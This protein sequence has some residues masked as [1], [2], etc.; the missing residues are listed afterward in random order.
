M[1]FVLFSGKWKIVATGVVCL[2]TGDLLWLFHSTRFAWWWARESQIFTLKE[3]GEKER[4]RTRRVYAG[5]RDLEKISAENIWGGER[6]EITW[7]FL[8]RWF[9]WLCGELEEDL[10]AMVG[11]LVRN[12]LKGSVDK[13]KVMVLNGEKGLKCA[14]H[15]HR[16]RLEHVLEFMYLR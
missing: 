8:C 10:K 14:V 4:G 15:V 3:I 13:T 1:G 11:C 5:F 6:V 7:P 2:K 12:G 9:T 16:M